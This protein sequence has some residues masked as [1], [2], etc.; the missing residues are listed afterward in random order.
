MKLLFFS[1]NYEIGGAEA[2]LIED[3]IALTKTNHELHLILP[4]KG[5]IS[6][7]LADVNINLHYV[8][9]DWWL[10]PHIFSLMLKLKFIRGFFLSAF[11]IKT[12]INKINPDV[13]ITNTMASPVA[14]LGA[15]LGDTKHIWYVH[16]FGKE[17]HQLN[18]ILGEKI[19]YKLIDKLSA[20]V[21]SDS[22]VVTEKLKKFFPDRSINTFYYS[23][24]IPNAAT[25][26]PQKDFYK[27]NFGNSV[28][29]LITG[30]VNEGK[31]QKDAIKAI[32]ILL[33]DYKIDAHLTIVGDRGGEYSEEIRNYVNTNNLSENITFV[34]FSDNI[35]SFY[36]KADFVLVCSACEAFGRVTIEAMK[37]QKVIIASN[38]GAN[39]ELIGN[40]ER[41]FLYEM[42]NVQH[43]AKTIVEARQNPEQL[44]QIS[45]VAYKWS[46]AVCN[47]DLHIKN[48]LNVIEN[49]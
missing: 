37:L 33:N 25:F 28:N 6:D 19:T 47:T 4:Q 18:A 26:L 34:S 45:E 31:R 3:L 44:H 11:K 24:D 8:N 43:L 41:G 5:K 35:Y 15:F 2:V 17:D 9:C 49:A 7:N 40:N 12:I 1:P 21:I 39:P 42:G 16:E 14:A 13:V 36:Q 22:F 23:V 29:I 46:W 10:T 32:E 38:T 30:R 20:Q 48:L 27:N